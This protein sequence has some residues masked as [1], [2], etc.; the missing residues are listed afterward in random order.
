MY[1]DWA[2]NSWYPSAMLNLSPLKLSGTESS[3]K[4][5][6]PSGWREL[7]TFTC[8]VSDQCCQLASFWHF[9][10]W[11][12]SLPA[13]QPRSATF[14]VAYRQSSWG[15]SF[16]RW[17]QCRLVNTFPHRLLACSLG[18]SKQ[19]QTFLL[20]IVRLPSITI[21]VA[22]LSLSYTSIY[23]SYHVFI[24]RDYSSP[25]SYVFSHLRPSKMAILEYKSNVGTLL[26]LNGMRMIRKMVT[27]ASQSRISL[28]C[29]K[30]MSI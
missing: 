21:R 13:N 29:V 11:S 22:F 20:S 18:G 7:P 15:I 17:Y 10:R 19:F 27:R 9:L 28:D 12:R 16:D 25:G 3:F 23:I 4:G 2:W 6:S 24:P 5:C 26:L 30:R 14:T 1:S 8:L